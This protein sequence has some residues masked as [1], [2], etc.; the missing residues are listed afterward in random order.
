MYNFSLILRCFFDFGNFFEIVE[1]IVVA[2]IGNDYI[3]CYN[4]MII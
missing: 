4:K 1:N 3:I 2:A